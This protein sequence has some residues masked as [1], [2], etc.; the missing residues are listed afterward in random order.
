MKVILISS[1]NPN[2]LCA[3]SVP[4]LTVGAEYISV[5]LSHK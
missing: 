5:D 1:R 4:N 2:V 3:S